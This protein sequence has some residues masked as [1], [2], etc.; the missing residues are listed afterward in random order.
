MPRKLQE[1]FRLQ[2]VR[3]EMAQSLSL[4][5]VGVKNYVRSS[6]TTCEI[7]STRIATSSP[8]RSAPTKQ[9]ELTVVR[10]P[11]ESLSD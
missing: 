5:L 2:R 6:L 1:E 10:S 3:G 8:A 11:L 9:A 4:E 7:V